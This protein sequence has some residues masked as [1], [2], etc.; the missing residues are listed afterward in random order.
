MKP[1]Q[2]DDQ[3]VDLTIDSRRFSSQR[4]ICQS[5]TNASENRAMGFFGVDQS[6]FVLSPS[7]GR[8]PVTN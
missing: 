3:V 5:K 7:C 6:R 4:V 2:I 8:R 1:S